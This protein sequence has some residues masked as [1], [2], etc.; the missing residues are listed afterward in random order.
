M[1]KMAKIHYIG[2]WNCPM[3]IVTTMIK[4]R[5]EDVTFIEH[6]HWVGPIE[7]LLSRGEGYL[8]KP[9]S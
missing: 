8:P 5:C 4:K 9:R 2:I 1:G 7:S 6:V 3:I